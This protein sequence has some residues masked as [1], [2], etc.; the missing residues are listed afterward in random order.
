MGQRY[1]IQDNS[2][3]DFLALLLLKKTLTYRNMTQLASCYIVYGG[4]HADL[5]WTL[6]TEIQ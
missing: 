3:T 2:P 6:W 5:I 1:T 4:R